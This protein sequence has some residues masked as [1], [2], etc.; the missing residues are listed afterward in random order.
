MRIKAQTKPGRLALWFILMLLVF[1]TR[2]V[3]NWITLN[4]IGRR[5]DQSFGL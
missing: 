3:A 1:E 2:L 5:L 4:R